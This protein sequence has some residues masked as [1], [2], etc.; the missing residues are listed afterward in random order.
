MP[1][2]DDSSGLPI[3]TQRIIWFAFLMSIIIYGVIASFVGREGGPEA[4]ALPIWVWWVLAVVGGVGV[5]LWAR[6]RSESDPGHE[7]RIIGWAGAEYVGILGLVAHFIGHIS[8]QNVY[9]FLGVA[10]VLILLQFP[11]D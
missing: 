8:L 9:P 7:T 11:R 10:F 1:K 6:Y 5:I 3:S 4:N 2:T